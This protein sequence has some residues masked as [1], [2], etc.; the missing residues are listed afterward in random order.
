MFEGSTGK[1][2]EEIHRLCLLPPQAWALSI[3]DVGGTLNI[4]V[5]NAGR[6]IEIGSLCLKGLSFFFPSNENKPNQ[7]HCVRIAT[8]LSFSFDPVPSE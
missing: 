8:K 6:R 5:V 7:Q 2:A 3:Q 4:S 1:D